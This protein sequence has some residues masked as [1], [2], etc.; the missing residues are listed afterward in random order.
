MPSHHAEDAHNQ[1]APPAEQIK[2]KAQKHV[3]VFVCVPCEQL[4]KTVTVIRALSDPNRRTKKKKQSTRTNTRM[5]CAVGL[6]DH[7]CARRR[8]ERERAESSIIAEDKQRH[9]CQRRNKTLFYVVAYLLCAMCVC[10]ML[11]MEAKRH[12]I[13]MFQII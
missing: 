8:R 10:A 2:Q 4:C 7:K 12:I 3:Y 9:T 6:Y 11:W 5:C 1:R 13:W